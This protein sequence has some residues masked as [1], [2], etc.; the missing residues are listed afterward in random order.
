MTNYKI[1]WNLSSDIFVPQNPKRKRNSAY[2][3]SDKTIV[4]KTF[5]EMVTAK[6]PSFA[7]QWTQEDR[8]NLF[9][10]DVSEMKMVDGTTSIALRWYFKEHKLYCCISPQC[11]LGYP[12][13]FSKE[14]WGKFK[15]KLRDKGFEKK[16]KPITLHTLI[17]IPEISVEMSRG[18]VCSSG[19]SR[20]N[21]VWH[22]AHAT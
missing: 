16:L 12:G 14:W 8:D 17:L 3:K 5:K 19:P 1:K 9:E 15:Q 6:K 4:A 20:C 22:E 10:I 7:Q 18:R 13:P 2:K 11:F 21:A